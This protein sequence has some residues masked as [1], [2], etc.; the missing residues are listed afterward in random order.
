MRQATQSTW[1]IN[2]AAALQM[3]AP[4][5]KSTTA[6]MVLT[7]AAVLSCDRAGCVFH[8]LGQAKLLLAISANLCDA[9]WKA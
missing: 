7:P 9:A 2:N 4:S 5:A 3:L 6:G 8:H 1:L